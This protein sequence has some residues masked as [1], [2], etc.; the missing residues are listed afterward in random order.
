MRCYNY[1]ELGH[2]ATKC[3]RSKNDKRNID[4]AELEAKYDA[5]LR[6]S[7]EMPTLLM[8][9]ELLRILH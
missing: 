3:R 2:F 7:K 5:L 6:S 9:Q 4:Y 1:D 8:R